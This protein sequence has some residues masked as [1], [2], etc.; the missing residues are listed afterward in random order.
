M[1]EQLVYYFLAHAHKIWVADS[2][3]SSEEIYRRIQRHAAKYKLE[4]IPI[5]RLIQYKLAPNTQELRIMINQMV[6]SNLAEWTDSQRQK[7][8]L[9]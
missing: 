4:T 6:E 5:R 7:F 8:R 2:V 3:R 1:A 9:K